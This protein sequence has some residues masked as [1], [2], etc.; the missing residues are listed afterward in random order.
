MTDLLSRVLRAGALPGVL[1]LAV[2]C[3]SDPAPSAPT[4]TRA[5][6]ALYGTGDLAAISLADGTV[7]DTLTPAYWS[8]AVA[9]RGDLARAVVLSSDDG[10]VEELDLTGATLATT[11]EETDALSSYWPFVATYA[12]DEAAIVT[13]GDP[14]FALWSP[15][16]AAEPFAFP[17]GSCLWDVAA[18][19]GGNRLFFADYCTAGG[20]IYVTDGAGA[21][22]DTFDYATGLAD[23]APT[24][25]SPVALAVS[26]G[27]TR[28][29]VGNYETDSSEASDDLLVFA[30]A[31]DGTLTFV[32]QVFLEDA[33]DASVVADL[34]DTSGMV[35]SPD[36]SEV[37]IAYDGGPT[38]DGGV[39]VYRPA[40]DRV[41][42][43]PFGA[44]DG[45]GATPCEIAVDWAGGTA[46]L[47]GYDYSY[48]R[49]T[50]EVFAVDV[51]TLAF[52]SLVFPPGS[53]PSG[54]A[55]Y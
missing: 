29:Y 8:N 7:V 47:P 34:Y 19:A 49:G 4:P 36:G 28:L 10:M 55:L 21:L 52:A 51:A 41:D 35:V 1:A 14:A 37:W 39:A 5:L 11:G 43:V 20:T 48:G 33:D 46:Y 32:K 17:D 6:V 12:G 53:A 27:G 31:A 45:T 26:P 24:S 25:A 22:L 9:V 13:W 30:V 18:S 23:V 44:G 50:D 3:S 42:V 15:P 16:A 2:A 40:T 38:A 54:I